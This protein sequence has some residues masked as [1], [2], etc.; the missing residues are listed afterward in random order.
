VTRTPLSLK[1]THNCH[2]KSKRSRHQL[3]LPPPIVTDHHCSRTS[4][5][6]SRT[7]ASAPVA[8]YQEWPFLGFLKRTKIKNETTYT[9]EFR[10]SHV[11]EHLQL[12]VLSEA[13][14]MRSKKETFAEIGTPRNTVVHSKVRS[15]TL[16][17]KRKRVPWTQEEHEIIL[18]T[19]EKDCPW[20]EI[21]VAFPHRTPGAIQVHYSTKLKK[22]Y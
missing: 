4:Q 16:Q 1:R 22:Q 5:S 9:L 19:K 17:A 8:E 21:Y 13:F 12:S 3:S 18:N 7:V 6:P 10:L 20:E 11:P 15:V 14:S 2:L